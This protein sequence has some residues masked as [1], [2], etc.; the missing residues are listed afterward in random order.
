M[1]NYSLVLISTI[2]IAIAQPFL[3]NAWTKVPAQWFSVEE[4]ATAVGIVIFANLVGVALGMVLTPALMAS[5]T[6]PAI[7]L[8]YGGIAAV[9][10]VIIRDTGTGKTGHTALPGWARGDGR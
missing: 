10:A 7:Q 1:T 3:L 8:L 9:S 4:R 6:I 5:M 2:G